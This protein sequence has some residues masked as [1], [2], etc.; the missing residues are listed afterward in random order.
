MRK[1]NPEFEELAAMQAGFEDRP[2]IARRD[3]GQEAAR[4]VMGEFVSGNYFRMFGLKPAAG[5]C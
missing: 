5:G 1:K 4:S 2:V 3:G